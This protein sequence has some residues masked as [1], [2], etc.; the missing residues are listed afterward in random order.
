[1][2]IEEFKAKN[3]HMIEGVWLPRVTSITGI[4]SKP[5]LF[6][7]YAKHKSFATAQAILNQAANWGTTV[8]TTIENFLR[9]DKEKIDKRL[10]PSVLAFQKWADNYQ[11]KILNS[12]NDI[13]KEVYD[14]ENYYSGTLDILLEIDG[15]YGILDI[16]TGSGIWNEYSLQLAAYLNAYNKNA[17]LNKKAKKRWIL[18]LD[19]YQECEICGAKK[20]NKLVEARITGGDR[21]CPHKFSKEKGVYEFKELL[22]FEEDIDGFLNAKNLWEWSNN[23]FLKKIKNYPKNKKPL[24]L[25]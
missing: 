3:G 1:M 11:I 6:Y 12:K 2:T 21:N 13:E 22:N 5:G 8:H 16:K 20:R 25:F 7:Y 18:R 9:G 14:F 23:N 17:P 10:E 24:K 4:I 19:Q 15:E